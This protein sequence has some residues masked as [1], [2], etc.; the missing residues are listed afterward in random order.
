[1]N[2]TTGKTEIT[3]SLLFTSTFCQNRTQGPSQK[4]FK[5]LLW[6]NNSWIQDNNISTLC[7][8]VCTC[9]CV[10]V[11][12]Y[13]NSI[14]IVTW[15]SDVQATNC[16]KG[17]GQQHPR[18]CA[19]CVCVL[20]CGLCG[21]ATVKQHTTLSHPGKQLYLCVYVFYVYLR[22]CC[23]CECL[24]GRIFVC[25]C[26]SVCLCVFVCMCAC[27]CD[28]IHRLCVPVFRV[29]QSSCHVNIPSGDRKSVV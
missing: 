15:L 8:C 25:A 5:V 16:S 4:L 22:V 14:P 29:C 24:S 13:C 23:S 11:C 2:N 18:L 17:T 12:V 19:S 3:N 1:M 20:H 28:L 7:L 9:L 6:G 27:A 21:Q 10:W 26:V